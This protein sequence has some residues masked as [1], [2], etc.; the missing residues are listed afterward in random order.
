MFELLIKGKGEQN[1]LTV[2]QTNIVSVE[3][4]KNQLFKL[5]LK[6]SACFLFTQRM[7]NLYASAH[8][9]TD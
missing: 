1:F 3:Q 5:I 8:M 9:L 6:C 4:I 7:L 2:C